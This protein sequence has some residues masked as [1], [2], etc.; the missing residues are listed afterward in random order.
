MGS[1]QNPPNLA[2]WR[3]LSAFPSPLTLDLL[4]DWGTKYVLVDESLVSR[5]ELILECL[6][7]VADIGAGD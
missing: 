7:N 2:Y 3:D 4:C 1:S 6:P 5:R